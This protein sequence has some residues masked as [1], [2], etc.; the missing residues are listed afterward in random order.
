M[1][2]LKDLQYIIKTY[3]NVLNNNKLNLNT[4]NSGRYGGRNNI[5][6]AWR[7]DP[8]KPPKHISRMDYFVPV[9]GSKIAPPLVK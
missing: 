3:I 7:E 9:K 5:L 6:W 2:R 1:G 4:S 8:S